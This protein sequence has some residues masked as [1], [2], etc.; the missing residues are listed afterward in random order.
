MASGRANMVLDRRRTRIVA[1]LGPAS[2]D[3]ATLEAL[4]LAG[5][6]VVRLNFSHGSPTTH[7]E[8]VQRVREIAER[9]GRTVTILQD[10]Q[11]PKLRVRTL[12]HSTVR[13]QP[14][15]TLVLTVDPD[16]EEGKI[17]LT[18]PE[19]IRDITPGQVLLLRDG[20][21]RLRVSE[22]RPPDV[23]TLVE[24]GGEIPD[25]SG[26]T[27]PGVEPTIPALTR[28]D[29][30]DLHLG[31]E[32]GVDWVAM[33]FVRTREDLLLLREALERAGGK[34]VRVMA[35]I[36]RPSAVDHYRE[37]L[38]VAD[39]VMVARGD[40]GVT[41]PLS[42]IPLVQKRLIREAR[43][44]GK[45]VI[46]ATQML[47]SMIHAPTPTRAEVTDVANAIFD[48]TDGVMLSA[49]TAVGAYP[50][51]AVKVMDRI[52]RAV[53][54]SREFQEAQ[55]LQRPSPEPTAPDAIAHAAVD[56]AEALPAQL[57]V[58]FTSSGYTAQRV[59]R[60]R[61]QVPILAL[62][63]SQSVVR[64]V[65]LFFGVRSM[66]AP[67]PRNTDEMVEVALKMAVESRLAFAGDPVVIVAGVPFGREGSTNLIRLA[68]IPDG[69]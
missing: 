25:R 43:K 62:T 32:V 33:S 55:L 54:A 2:R 38:D 53:E 3:P 49:E 15:Q 52:A 61:P 30:E 51:E 57:I 37:I 11:G 9:L 64:Q 12:P 18:F 59:A 48:G 6:D 45:P 66:L 22:V 16:G 24:V 8:T 7:R 41:L 69:L 42:Q 10:L 65:N 31:V 21:I 5:V 14:G 46:T 39:G 60:F 19:L 68:R 47:E 20:Q 50:V 1:T 34:E 17:R 56:V 36:E 35:K 40:L 23:V 13:V 67:T 44:V 27:L 26:L 28:K 29:L 58:V 63:P 4:F